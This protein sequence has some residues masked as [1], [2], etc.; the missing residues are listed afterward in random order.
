M[1]IG[2]VARAGR[3]GTRR[4][5]VAPRGPETIALK[6]RPP[7]T[8]QTLSAISGADSTAGIELRQVLRWAER[9]GE[10][11]VAPPNRL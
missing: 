10:A 1:G 4:V 6:I 11:I 7:I 3:V 8:G 5:F 2:R 9:T